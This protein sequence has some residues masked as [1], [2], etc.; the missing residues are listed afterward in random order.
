[1]TYAATELTCSFAGSMRAFDRDHWQGLHGPGE[2]PFLDWE[3]LNLLEESGCVGEESGWLP[4]HLAVHRESEGSR[5]L[6]AAA[7][8]YVK[9]HSEGEFVFD[10]PFAEAAW[11]SG[12]EYYPK[13]VGMSPFTPVSGYRLLVD[14]REDRAR[15]TTRA[16]QFL[17]DHCR[18]QGIR[19]VNVLFART[20]AARELAELGM[21]VW[22]H[23]GFEWHNPGYAGFG[24]YE[25]AFSRNQRRNIRRE[26]AA[27]SKQGLALRTYEAGDVTPERMAQMFGFY[28]ATNDKFGP[29]GC[30]YLNAEAFRLMAERWSMR[31]LLVSAEDA[32]GQPAGM[33]LCVHKDDQLYGRYWGGREDVDFLHFNVCYYRPIRWAIERGMSRFDPGMGGAHKVRR[34]FISV[35]NYSAHR[36]FDPRMRMLFGLNVERMNQLQVAELDAMNKAVPFK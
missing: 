31:L 32:S 29:W 22:F 35:I 13:L 3:W 26:V 34:G 18:E 25:D 23:Q 9:Y 27:P 17:L 6:V 12:M 4:M 30:K 5:R 15:I 8:L 14:A 10:Y 2:S 11:Q 21:A 33:S 1:M 7:P 16:M 36:H 24:D 28:Q 19:S 20:E